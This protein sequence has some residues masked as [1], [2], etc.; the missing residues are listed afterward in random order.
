MALVLSASLP[1]VAGAAESEKQKDKRLCGE[2][3]SKLSDE[4]EIAEAEVIVDAWPITKATSLLASAE[5]KHQFGGYKSCIRLASRG[6]ELIAPHIRN[7]DGT[8]KKKKNKDDEDEG[9]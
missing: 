1:P 9:D 7:P 5:F 3:V 8:L 6:R 2:L 4:L